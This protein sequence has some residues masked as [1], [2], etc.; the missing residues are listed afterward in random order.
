MCLGD[1]GCVG[2]VRGSYVKLFVLWVTYKVL[3]TLYLYIFWTGKNKKHVIRITS[4]LRFFKVT[5]IS[6]GTIRLQ[7]K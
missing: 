7:V 3:V 5:G 1:P 4:D 2:S 6:T